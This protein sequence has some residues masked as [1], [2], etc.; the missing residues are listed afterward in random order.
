MLVNQGDIYFKGE[1][2][3]LNKHKPKFQ[4]SNVVVVGGEF[5]GVILKT[6]GASTTGS[7]RG[8][9]YEVYV[10]Y[11]GIIVELDECDIEHYVYDKVLN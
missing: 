8:I 10:R 2:V 3:C 11:S 9:H 7:K 6:W 4:F 5:I 1:K